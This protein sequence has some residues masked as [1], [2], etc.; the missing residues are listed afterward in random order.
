MVVQQTQHLVLLGLLQFLPLTTKSLASYS[1]LCTAPSQQE[2]LRGLSQVIG[3]WPPQH[4]ANTMASKWKL[5]QSL[6]PI[7]QERTNTAR[8]R[9]RLLVDGEKILN[10]RG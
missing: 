4:Q 2:N 7:A 9:T 6:D 10:E 3:M 8:P 5:A 1:D